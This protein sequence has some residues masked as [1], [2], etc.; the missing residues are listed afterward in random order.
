MLA[1]GERFNKDITG[2]KLIVID[3]C[4]HVPNAE[5]PAEFNAAVLKFLT[6]SAQ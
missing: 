2:S 6:E 5:K 4:G 3:Q 1:D